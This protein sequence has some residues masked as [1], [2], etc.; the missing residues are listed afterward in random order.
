MDCSEEEFVESLA[1]VSGCLK[2]TVGFVAAVV[3]GSNKK[4]GRSN[5][6][7]SDKFA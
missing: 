1:C 2:K 6:I 5:R 3:A 4:K 7:I